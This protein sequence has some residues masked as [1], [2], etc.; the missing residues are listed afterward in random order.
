MIMKRLTQRN[1]QVILVQQ[2]T[3]LR[4]TEEDDGTPFTRG[5]T[6]DG[7]VL[8]FIYENLTAFEAE[9]IFS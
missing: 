7:V 9:Y 2:G 6:T 1:G 5:V 4:V 8:D 3:I